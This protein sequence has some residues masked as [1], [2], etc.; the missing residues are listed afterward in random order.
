MNRT[1]TLILVRASVQSDMSVFC[2]V[3][4]IL[5]TPRS[6]WPEVRRESGMS[7]SMMLLQ[8][9]AT[10]DFAICWRVS[11]VLQCAASQIFPS[12]PRFAST[13]SE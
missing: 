3:S 1:R 12:C 9:S 2:F 11:F 13:C 7:G 10:S 5:T 8:A 6:R 4:W